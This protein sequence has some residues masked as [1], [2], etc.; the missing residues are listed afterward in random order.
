MCATHRLPSLAFHSF[1]C[2]TI[3][4]LVVDVENV[5]VS[6]WMCSFNIVQ[7]IV[8]VL[9]IRMLFTSVL[10][11]VLFAT[12]STNCERATKNRFSIS[13]PRSVALWL[14]MSVY[15][16]IFISRYMCF[17]SLS[18]VLRVCTFYRFSFTF[19]LSLSLLLPSIPSSSSL[20]C[21][22]FAKKCTIC[23]CTLFLFYARCR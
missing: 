21:F 4:S 1:I 22:P 12:D 9:H 8:F 7:C 5:V 2:L 13:L 17:S 20:C 19:V 18:Y 11:N 15:T 6:V 10:C 16:W 23:P 3:H 14:T